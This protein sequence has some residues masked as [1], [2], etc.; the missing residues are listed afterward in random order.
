MKSEQKR[1]VRKSY[2]LM[3]AKPNGPKHLFSYKN[4]IAIKLEY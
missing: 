2:D 1:L 3:N 4:F